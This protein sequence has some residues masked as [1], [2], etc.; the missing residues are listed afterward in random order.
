MNEMDSNGSIER[1]DLRLNRVFNSKEFNN[2]LAKLKVK[3][4]MSKLG[5][6]QIC[7]I[8]TI[9]FMCR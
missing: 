1:L 7:K 4:G 5:Y 2:A 8:I 9:K 6:I 3:M